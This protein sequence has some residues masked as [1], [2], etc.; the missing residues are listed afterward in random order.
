MAL[1]IKKLTFQIVIWVFMFCLY[2]LLT[3]SAVVIEKM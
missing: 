3:Q 1:I 2:V